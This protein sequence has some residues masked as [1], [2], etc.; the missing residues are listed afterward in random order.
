[1]PEHK[2]NRLLLD[3]LNEEF[4]RDSNYMAKGMALEYLE[5]ALH[6]LKSQ[7]LKQADL[8]KRMGVNPA[9]ISRIFSFN[10][11]PNLTLRTLARIAVALETRPI[12]GLTEER[13]IERMISDNTSTTNAIAGATS[14]EQQ[15]NR[16][17]EMEW[18]A[19]SK[20]GGTAD[21]MLVQT[22]T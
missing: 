22:I 5:D 14:R 20:L 6:I 11:S 1:M 3:E 18:Q 21:A 10:T 17:E 19:I 13:V 2:V 12:I 8:A 4:E 9:F 16:G 15:I 7:G